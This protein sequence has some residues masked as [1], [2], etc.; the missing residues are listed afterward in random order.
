MNDT[1]VKYDTKN[2][3]DETYKTLNLAYDFFNKELFGGKLPSC[4][5]TMQRKSKARGYFCPDRFESR[6][7]S[8]FHVHEIALNPKFFNDR[9]DLDILSTLVHEMC[10]VWQQEFGSPSRNNY[11]NKE[12]AIKMDEVGLTPSNT[13]E[14]DG[15]R[16]GQSMS[17]YVEKGGKYEK[18]AN[19]FFASHSPMLFQDSPEG[20][21]PKV[22]RNK[23]KYVC[24]SCGLKA[25]AKPSA[26]L[27]C[28]NCKVEMEEE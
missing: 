18:A 19:V 4:L 26:T 15:R 1:S 7:E 9:T 23:T 28:G 12:W 24:L 10:H 5:I 21:K 25:W 14:E 3:T 8:K 2:P 6:K 11:H 17:H 13:G 27:I 22:N 16:T 20:L